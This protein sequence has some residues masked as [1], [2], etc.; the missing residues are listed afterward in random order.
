METIIYVFT[1]D[2]IIYETTYITK[3]DTGTGLQFTD[4]QTGKSVTVQWS[5]LDYIST[6]C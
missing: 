6:K 4:K 5:N 2:R 3:S 1:K